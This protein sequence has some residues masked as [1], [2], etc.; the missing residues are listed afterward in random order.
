MKIEAKILKD[1]IKKVSLDAS[2]L[3]LNLA[4]TDDGITT[5]VRNVS[6]IA[7]TEGLL[8][9]EAFESYDKLDNMFIRNSRFFIEILNSFSDVVELEVIE[10]HTLKIFDNKREAFIMLAE[11]TIC[12]N[13]VG[14]AKP[15]ID[16]EVTVNMLKK[17]LASAI[18]DMGLLKVTNLKIVKDGDA[19]YFQ[20]G[21]QREYDYTRNKVV[22]DS[23]GDV[24]VGV[25]DTIIS[26]FNTIGDKFSMNLGVKS[27]IVI[28][29]NTDFMKVETI[30]API[31]DN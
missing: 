4:F 11:E 17:E 18:K 14:D 16:N 12:D 15:K 13:L 8:K 22:C 6:N 10:D 5:G 23:E 3:T 1:Y 30:I 21:K 31:V 24:D 7:M 25:G 29:E 28:T 20:V 2:I 27:P 19:L 26:V 9:K